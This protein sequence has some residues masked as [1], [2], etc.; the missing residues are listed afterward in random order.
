MTKSSQNPTQDMVISYLTIRKAVGYLGIFF[1]VVL[2]LGNWLIRDCGLNDSVSSYYYSI[3]GCFFD[4]TLCAVGLFLFTYKGYDRVDQWSSNAGGLFALCIVFFRTNGGGRCSVLTLPDSDFL[5]TAH[6][7]SAGLFFVTMA[8]ISLFLFTKTS[9]SPT[10]QKLRRNRV[11]KACGIIM[12]VFMSLIPCLKI[13]SI[14]PAFFNYVPEFWFESIV[15]WAFGFSWLTKGE[16]L[17]K[18]N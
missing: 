13:K 1:P 9:G 7:L 11:Y 6:Y 18:D 15:L 14:P 12:L 10:K 8:C 17:L 4:G 5:N 3:M 2:A 16:G